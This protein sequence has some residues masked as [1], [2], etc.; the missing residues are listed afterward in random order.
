MR[1]SSWALLY[2]YAVAVGYAFVAI[3]VAIAA[4]NILTV[5][6]TVNELTLVEEVLV[7]AI[8]S[9]RRQRHAAHAQQCG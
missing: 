4:C 3:G 7:V 8:L 5:G 9:A 2:G 6:S 1:F